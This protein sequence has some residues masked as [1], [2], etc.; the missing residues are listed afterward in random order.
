MSYLF[1]EYK[2][3][4]HKVPNLSHVSIITTYRHVN[5]KKNT[6]AVKNIKPINNSTFLKGKIKK[7]F[8]A[9]TNYQLKQITRQ[10]YQLH[11]R[12]TVQ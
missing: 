9:A 4:Y 7:H 5:N 12:K 1:Q 2:I 8:T 6:L 10:H 11:Q 3:Y